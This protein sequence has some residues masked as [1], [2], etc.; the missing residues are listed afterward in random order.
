MAYDTNYY[1]QVRAVNA[2][3]NVQADT[4]TWF[5]FRTQIAP[6]GA[7][8]KVAPANFAVDQ[9]LSLTLSWGASAG[10][11]ITYEYCLDTAPCYTG[12]SW[13]PAGTAL[14]AGVSGL[15][16]ETTYYWQVRA[17]NTSGTTYADGAQSW[18][19]TTPVGL[20]GSFGKT[21]PANNALSQ[22]VSSNL[23]WGTSLGTNVRYEYCLSTTTCTPGSTWQLAGTNTS[24][25]VS[26]LAFATTYYWQVRAVNSAGTTYANGGT[27]WQFNTLN[28]P[29]QP[30]SKLSP[31]NT[32]VDPM[33]VNVVLQWSTG[34]GASRY[35]YCVDTVSHASG[36][37]TCGPGWV[38]R[39]A[40]ASS[41]LNLAYNQTYYWQVY[42]ENPQGTAQADGGAWWS[43]TTLIAPPASFTKVVPADDAIDQPLTP[44]LYWATPADPL[45]TYQYCLDTATDCPGGGWTAVAENAP[46][47]VTA[48]LA[49]NTIYYWQ[50]RATNLGGTTYANN[51]YW[52]FTTIQSPPTSSNQSFSVAED[53][54]LIDT[55]TATSN[56]AKVFALYGSTP[57]GTLNLSSNGSF[58]FTPAAN[59]N[60]T[61]IFQFVVSDGYSPPVGPYTATITVTPVNDPPSL[62]AITDQQVTAGNQATFWVLGTDPDQPYGDTLTY[63]IDEALPAG[64]S[65]NPQS[66]F[67]RWTVPASHLGGVFNFTVRVT[68]SGSSSS[69]RTAKIT[70]IAKP[71]LLL[72]FINR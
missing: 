32:G 39:E 24:A 22:P 61:V 57:A 29:P 38:L 48:S 18:R 55:L 27:V 58:V 30:F 6:P 37:A 68:D 19:F 49:Y 69:T 56:Y 34:T 36:D 64:A 50:V 40:T 3:G 63:S 15:L 42:A 11:G 52:T 25:S 14:S 28:A 47:Q 10:T 66:G 46:I 9:P 33:P 45:N 16:S 67:F 53:L 8:G 59:F 72:P 54:P 21:S 31:A 71:R 13:T 26:G 7:F 35:F 43:F 1:W 51:S 4:G 41:P 20:P 12:S 65:I 2:T 60:D 5:S 44:W 17:V 23:T 70:V 62:A